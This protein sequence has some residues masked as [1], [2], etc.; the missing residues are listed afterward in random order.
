MAGNTDARLRVVV[1][2]P[3]SEGD[4]RF[5]EAREPRIELIRDH[6]L[7]PPMRHAA[8]FAGDPSFVRTSAQQSRFR[9]MVDSA[10]VL[11]G[12]PDMSPAE[13]KRTA[14]NNPRLRW[15]QTMAA[16]GG[17]QVEAAGLSERQLG[18]IAFS[19]SAGVHAQMLAEFAIFGV[20]AG[21]KTLPRLVRQ[22]RDH[23][24]SERWAMQRVVG[25]TALVVGLGNIGRRVAEQ[26]AALGVVVIGVGRRT[27]DSNGVHKVVH[28]RE[29]AAV[30][31]EVD[32]VIAALPGTAK[33]R[34]ILGAEFF[35]ALKPGA[36]VV[37][38][39]RGSVIDE[40]ELIVALQDGRVSFAALDVFDSEPLDA[41]SLLWELPNVLVS[42]H[43]AALSEDEEHQIAE[44][45]AENATRFL[46][47]VELVN[48]VD[49]VEFY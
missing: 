42:P 34:G 27:L 7:L 16:G 46:D 48:H 45:F 31:A 9:A 44:L 10:D 49:P 29:L 36:V 21:A 30:A 13:L 40:A 28:P 22:Q 41:A 32:V 43:T 39:G 35:A 24:W 1:A 5:I 19:T 2:V 17:S 3:L 26:L 33:T 47:G 14:D 6:E 25:Q 4:C 11:F 23:Q 12:V 38:V 18:R 20:F 15:V 37:N 8:D